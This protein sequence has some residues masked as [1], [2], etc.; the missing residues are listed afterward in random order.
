MWKSQETIVLS[1][2]LSNIN[3]FR[4]L[5]CDQIIVHMQSVR[6]TYCVTLYGF[7]FLNEF[8]LSLDPQHVPREPS[9]QAKSQVT[10]DLVEHVLIQTKQVR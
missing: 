7:H 10:N 1:S 4:L 5:F 3:D 2:G 6:M 9:N 8:P